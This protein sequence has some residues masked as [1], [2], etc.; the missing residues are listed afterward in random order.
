MITKDGMR[1]KRMYI[2]PKIMLIKFDNEISLS[3]ESAPPDGPGE[4]VSL[5]PAYFNDNPFKVGMV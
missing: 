4:G 5:A 3:L 2:S 1:V